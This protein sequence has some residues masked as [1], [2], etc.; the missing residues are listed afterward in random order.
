MFMHL[1]N[2]PRDYA[3][4]APGAIS[5]LL[6]ADGACAPREGG[7]GPE[8]E[9]WLGAHH[10]SPAE[11][12]GPAGAGEAVQ[13]D[14]AP[15]TLDAWIAEDPARALGRHVAGLRPGA[16]PVLPF[17]MKVL[18]AG[19]PLSLQTHPTLE[20]AAAGYAAEDAAGIPLGASFRNYRDRLHKPE[21]LLAVS[22]RFAALAGFR[23]PAEAGA[24]IRRLAEAAVPAPGARELAEL[25]ERLAATEPEAAG[26]RFRELIEEL[27]GSGSAG[28]G[29][30]LAEAAAIGAHA[31]LAAGP[32]A[33]ADADGG[34]AHASDASSRAAA[35]LAA[36]LAARYPGD[37]GVIIALLMN[38][39]ELRAGE[40][41]FLAPGTLHAYLD[42]VGVEVMAASDNVLRGGLTA[43]HVDVPELLATLDARV[44][45]EPRIEPAVL[46]PGLDAY[47]PGLADFRVLVA[48]GA[49]EGTERAV[50]L[51]GPAIALA[52]SGAW[53]LR[54][55]QGEGALRAGEALAVT[56]DEARLRIE[57]EGL[58]V[59]ATTDPAGR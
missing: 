8:A 58:L 47:M 39:I 30:R 57:G 14:A 28:R 53:R 1:R 35:E 17:L 40:A 7:R 44:I 55:A 27:L 51:D 11:I 52:L 18:A 22:E 56:P 31:M 15:A 33:A 36:L 5:D 16:G 6:G 41:I 2:A 19:G 24:A 20:Q 49:G 9:L 38:R 23:A 43:K 12:V 3:W 26:A 25:A 59:L 37:P 54:G 34:A 10:G 13:A 4:G 29:R 46:A 42:G 50:E 21:L 45:P 48:R 32:D